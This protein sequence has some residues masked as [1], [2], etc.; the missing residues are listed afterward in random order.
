MVTQNKSH[1]LLFS[2]NL[3]T[4]NIRLQ[5]LAREGFWIIIGQL[6]TIFGSLY[7][8]KIITTKL[9]PSLF[10]TVSLLLSVSTFF[11]QVLYGGVGSGV[12][13]FFSVAEIKNDLY[14][15]F[16]NSRKIVFK[17]SLFLLFFG[18]GTVVLLSFI[19]YQNL[20]FLTI[21]T[22]FISIL[23]GI[24]SVLN[25]FQNSARQRDIVAL[26]NG[27]GVILKIVI[28]LSLFNLFG[29]NETILVI[30]ILLSSAIALISQLIFFH[31]KWKRKITNSSLSAYNWSNEIWTYSLSVILWNGFMA[32]YQL[33]D[34]WALEYYNSL[35]DV[36][37][38]TVLFQLGYTP[39]LLVMTNL[40]AFLSPIIY[41]RAGDGKNP[42]KNKY[43][44]SIITK[45]IWL[46]FSF[47]V[48][49]F[50]IA[51]FFHRKIFGFLVSKSY[52]DYSYLLPVLVLSAGV[53]SAGQILN[54]K[55][56]SQIK[57]KEMI[58]IKI[59]TSVFGICLNFLLSAFYGIKGVLVALFVYSIA[60]FLGMYK[61]SKK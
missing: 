31:Y 46:T 10:G 35:K 39:T 3:V 29:A 15:Y 51:Y 2:K 7:F 58:F 34:K 55:M 36:G 61:I 44:D 22:I 17:I 9:E 6:F 47:S 30:S 28:V 26:N 56:E 48:I 59:S 24:I 60:N 41:Q 45:L 50:F 53:F 14:G 49:G 52:L 23:N 16:E 1:K 4:K 38:Y 32:L 57:V 40:L 12:A 20:I 42:V 21:L 54:I 19:G 25:N 11:S 33:S 27:L 37:V 13:R 8:I 5:N 18:G 43:I